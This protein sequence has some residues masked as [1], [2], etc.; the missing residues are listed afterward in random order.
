[1]T[2]D[3]LLDLELIAKDLL[4]NPYDFDVILE[5]VIEAFEMGRNS[6]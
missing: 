6:K 2:K 3:E 5:T 4:Q 1:M